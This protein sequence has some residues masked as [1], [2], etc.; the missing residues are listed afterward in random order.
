MTQ[1]CRFAFAGRE[2]IAPNPTASV[3]VRHGQDRAV[4][5]VALQSQLFVL[6]RAR[7]AADTI[8]AE[9]RRV[10]KRLHAASLLVALA[11]TVPATPAFAQDAPIAEAPP[12]AAAPVAAPPDIAPTDPAAP[13]EPVTPTYPATPTAPAAPTEPA[14]PA[15]AHEEEEGSPVSARYL[16]G[17]GVELA[18]EDG[19]YALAIK[20]R[21][22]LRGTLVD[23]VEDDDAASTELIARRI[24]LTLSGHFVVP[25]LTYNIQL[26]FANRDM[27]SD[28]RT[29]LLDAFI[30]YAPVR[31]FNLRVGQT[32]VPFNRQTVI[33]S[34]ALQF[35][36][37]SV[38][39]SELALERD[40][41]IYAF[42]KDL[43]GLGKRLQYQLGVFGG[44]GRNRLSSRSGLLWVARLE[45]SP[46]GKFDSY[47]ES[48]HARSSTPGLQLGFGGALNKNTV[49]ERSTTGTSYTLGGFDYMH[50]EA[51]MMFKWAG[52]SLQA[53][54][55]WRHA[56][57]Q[58]LSALQPDGT[59]QTEYAR[60][61]WGYFVQAGYYM[62]VGL[63]LAARYGDL[64]PRAGADPDLE[65]ERELG[66][67][68]S[69]YFE[70]HVLK[71]QADYFYLFGDTLDGGRHQV[72]VQVQLQF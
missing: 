61:A 7:H 47:S 49:R 51:D 63:E 33:S 60:P 17:E 41:G 11:L 32:K 62:P 52:F 2:R 40:V 50:L 15:A 71:V 59:T 8:G 14:A 23:S 27:E 64:H 72:R 20:G 46:F 39:L 26:G 13:T 18:S 12:D 31:D 55:L 10:M 57:V 65:R 5:H 29:P 37:R 4:T 48:D 38:V 25:E 28:L 43:F 21:L 36:D 53:E 16:V 3:T 1:Q 70:E 66:G 58:S 35:T 56:P 69:W 44:D 68:A 54:W 6:L 42:S 24:R 34:S 22:Q 19:S 67:A 9:I 30:G 45:V